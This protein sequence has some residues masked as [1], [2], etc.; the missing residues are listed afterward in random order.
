MQGVPHSA[1]SKDLYCHLQVIAVHKTGMPSTKP[2]RVLDELHLEAL[3]ITLA[4]GV[5][6][7]TPQISRTQHC[8]Q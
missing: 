5:V 3:N 4:Q 7:V 6:E 1:I 8:N 2:T